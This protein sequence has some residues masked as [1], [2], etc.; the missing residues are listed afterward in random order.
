NAVGHMLM[1]TGP[2]RSSGNITVSLS[3]QP[4]LDLSFEGAGKGK[5]DLRETIGGHLW[6]FTS[7][8]GSALAGTLDGRALEPLPIDKGKDVIAQKGLHY[9]DGT[10]VTIDAL[11]DTTTN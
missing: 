4:I 9:A 6:R 7:A 10:A 1:T 3:E 11:P 5:L 2:N 8:D